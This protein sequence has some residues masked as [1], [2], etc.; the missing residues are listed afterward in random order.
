MYQRF[1]RRPGT[2]L[3]MVAASLGV[4]LGMGACVVDVAMGINAKT[5]LQSA[6][7]SAAISASYELA[8]TGNTAGVQAAAADWANRN[9]A[10]VTPADVTI[11]Q[12][13][14]GQRAVT[15]KTRKVIETSFGR[16]FNIPSF[17]VKA[18]ATA[19]LGG[20][21]DYPGE[22]VPFGIPS[23]TVGNRW[24]VLG[25]S[26]YEELNFEPG[27]STRLHLKSGGGGGDDGNFQALADG[28]TGAGSYSRAIEY[29]L[30]TKIKRGDLVA[31]ETGNMIGPT[32]NGIKARLARPGGENIL[33]PLIAKE[34]W[35]SASGRTSVRVI[36][37]AAATLQPMGSGGD[38]Y[39]EFRRRVFGSPGSMAVT[40]TPGVHA[41][42]LIENPV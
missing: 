41:P 18:T 17:E 21:V 10:T 16:I 40:D 11:W 27:S 33:V 6:V 13:A 25:T 29:G 20:L 9:G 32:Q 3:P 34:D 39:A 7:D 31:T 35:D 42:V 22:L 15:L 8:T 28:S 24:Y 14:Q 37:L 1:S 19:A 38:V 30:S 5:Q 2:V 36:G 23:Y 12:T 4:L 26:G